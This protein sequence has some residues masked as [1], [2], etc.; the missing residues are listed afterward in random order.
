[1]KYARLAKYILA[2]EMGKGQRATDGASIYLPKKESNECH[3]VP[4]KLGRTTAM[5]RFPNMLGFPPKETI[6]P[7]VPSIPPFSFASALLR[8][9]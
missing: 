6:E 7:A 1:M 9:D 3:P 2:S 4:H 8:L 5:L